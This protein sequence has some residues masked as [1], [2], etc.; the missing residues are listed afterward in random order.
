MKGLTVLAA[1]L[2]AAPRPAHATETRGQALVEANCARCHATGKKGASPHP[3]APPLRE[4]HER[5]PLDALEEAFAEGI[6]VGHPD[7]PEFV[8]QPEQIRAIIDYI[9]TLSK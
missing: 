6:S 3:Q 9:A 2:C 8:A 4:L 5:Y 7:M 1:L